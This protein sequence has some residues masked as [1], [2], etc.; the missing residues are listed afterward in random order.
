MINCKTCGARLTPH[1]RCPPA[2]E[3]CDPEYDPDYWRTIYA[4]DWDDAAEEYCERCDHEEPYYAPEGGAGRILVR[5]V[6]GEEVRAFRVDAQY[7]V[8]YAAH[9]IELEEEE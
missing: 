4:L 9:S 3:V 2:W 7:T 6:G 1:H 5:E 8:E